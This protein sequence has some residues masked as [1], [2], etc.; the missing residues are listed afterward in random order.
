MV[1][2]SV[3]YGSDHTAIFPV[4]YLEPSMANIKSGMEALIQ[5]LQ[6]SCVDGLLCIAT[7]ESVVEA[8]LWLLCES[9]LEVSF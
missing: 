5:P 8:S 9:G 2:I 3:T 6:W 1:I 7:V 4:M